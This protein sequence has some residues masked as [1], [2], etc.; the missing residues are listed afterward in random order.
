MDETVALKVLDDVLKFLFKSNNHR[1]LKIEV[2]NFVELNNFVFKYKGNATLDEIG[3]NTFG[4]RESLILF[5]QRTEEAI[6]Y[7]SKNNFIRLN[8]EELSLT[9]DGIIQYSKGYVTTY[10]EQLY[11]QNRLESF[12]TF[13]RNF[14]RRMLWI[15]GAIALGTIVAMI[16]Y[17]F[18]MI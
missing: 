16:Y 1:A 2:K 7:L 12:D 9:Y 17:I 5:N 10:T 3:E 8:G 6:F 11:V 18:E 13:Q 14:S 15:N 4:K